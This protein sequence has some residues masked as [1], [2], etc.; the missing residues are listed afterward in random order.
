MSG[1]GIH[2]ARGAFQGIVEA[3][4]RT[5]LEDHPTLLEARDVSNLMSADYCKEVL[6]LS[7]ANLAL[8]RHRDQGHMVHGHPRY[9]KHLYAGQLYVCSQWWKD[10]HCSNASVLLALVSGI[11]QRKSAHPGASR[12]DRHIRDLTDFIRTNSGSSEA[13]ADSRSELPD[14][15]RAIELRYAWSCA[16]CDVRLSVGH[17]AYWSPLARDRVWCPACFGDTQRR[18]SRCG[19]K[20]GSPPWPR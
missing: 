13:S 8:L 1:W 5:L 3:L 11:A 17:T 12:L 18:E 16:A 19:N 4:M 10:H 9:W 7:I 14:E 20:P 15:L 6:G 2:G